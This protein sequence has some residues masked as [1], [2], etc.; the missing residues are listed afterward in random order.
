MKKHFVARGLFAIVFFHQFFVIMFKSLL[1]EAVLT[2]P[3][4]LARD[5]EIFRQGAPLKK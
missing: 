3:T 4:P 5:R 1:W 2:F